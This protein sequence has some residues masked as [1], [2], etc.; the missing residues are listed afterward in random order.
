MNFSVRSV[1]KMPGLGVTLRRQFICLMGMAALLGSYSLVSF[2]GTIVIQEGDTWRYFKGRSSGPPVQ[3]G[4]NWTERGYDDTTGWGEGPSGFGYGDSDDATSFDDMRD[5]FAALF[6]R[7]IFTINDPT[8]ITHLTLAV[9][10]DDGFVAYINDTEI[11]RRNLGGEPVDYM[12]LAIKPHEASRGIRQDKDVNPQAKEYI[13]IDPSVLV[14]GT[15]VLA[16]SGHNVSVES[17]DFSLTAE[18]STNV[19]LIRGPFIQRPNSEG[20]KVVWH[21]DALTTSAVEYGLDTSYSKGTVSDGE[22]VREHTITLTGLAPGTEHFYRIRSDGVVL[23]EGQILRT[24]SAAQQPYRFAVIGDFGYKDKDGKTSKIA[25]QVNAVKPD[26]LMTVG[27]NIYPDGQPGDYDALWFRP[28]RASMARAPTYPAL[29]NHDIRA[30]KGQWLVDY[31]HLPRNGPPG[32][33]E[34]NYSFD[35]GNAHVVVVES[36]PFHEED[37][38]AMETIEAWLSHDLALTTKPWKFVGLHHPP[39]TSRGYHNDE[40]FVKERLAPIFE[41]FGVQLVFQGHNHWFERL[42]PING[43]YYITTGAGGRSLH[44]I[45]HRKPYSAKLVND[46]YSFTLVDIDGTKLTLRAIDQKGSEIDRFHLDI[47]HPFQMDGLLDD[48]SWKRASHGLDLY[49]AL[50]GHTLY[51]ATQDAGEGSDHFIFLGDQRADIRQANWAKAGQV[52]TWSAF[53]ADENDNGFHGWYGSKE[54]RL[55]AAHVYRSVTS[56]LNNNG[57][58]GNGVLEGT[59]DLVAHFGYLPSKIYVAAAPYKTSTSGQL[60]VDA[61]APQGDGNGDIEP[62]EFLELDTAAI[63][64]ESRVVP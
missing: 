38:A 6:I 46:V 42:N 47:G 19:N 37:T 1:Y 21:T 22:R 25:A 44:G 58:N 32:L 18:L 7:K 50:R 28:Y 14:Q 31:F 35:Y 29:G 4:V 54:E 55:A 23:H 20:V 9:D 51:L 30:G 8:T 63:T 16:V 45:A 52:M 36:N 10:Y 15:N 64:L 24:P 59:I 49:V 56:G 41:R 61:Q 57:A 60:V 53:L 17:S 48:P 39:H 3:N 62:D 26:W 2:A 5:E 27:D 12:T 43:V 34:R 11:A 33:E 40:T 13:V